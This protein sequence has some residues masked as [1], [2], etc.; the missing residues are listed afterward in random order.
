MEP[1]IDQIKEKNM[2][3]KWDQIQ[4]KIWNQIKKYTQVGKSGDQKIGK[5]Q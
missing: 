5:V 4:E 3:S 2:E 1:K